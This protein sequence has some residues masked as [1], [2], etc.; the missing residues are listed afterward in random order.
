MEIHDFFATVDCMQLNMFMRT[1]RK[2]KSNKSFVSLGHNVNEFA[3]KCAIFEVLFFCCYAG[4]WNVYSLF[5]ADLDVTNECVDANIC[6]IVM[7]NVEG[8]VTE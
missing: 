1:R 8:F 2:D 3:Q 5:L 6:Q 4:G 7:K